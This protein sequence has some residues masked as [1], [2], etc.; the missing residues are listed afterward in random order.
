MEII[1]CRSVV[2]EKEEKTFLT[3]KEA[4]DSVHI[5][6]HI[7]FNCFLKKSIKELKMF[8]KLLT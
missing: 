1:C 2:P 3:I 8:K 7:C 6:E 5:D 4:Q